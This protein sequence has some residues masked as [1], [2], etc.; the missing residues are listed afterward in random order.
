MATKSCLGWNPVGGGARQGCGSTLLLSA[1]FV[2]AGT[3]RQTLPKDSI[4]GSSS[5][6]HC[7]PASGLTRLPG[8]RG[9]AG[10]DQHLLRIPVKSS[11]SPEC[12]EQLATAPLCPEFCAPRA[13]CVRAQ[14][15]ACCPTPPPP[16]PLLSG[17]H[18]TS[19]ERP[20]SPL[21]WLWPRSGVARS[22]SSWPGSPDLLKSD[23]V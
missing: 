22:P 15:P 12:P 14:S 16:P 6:S 21:M 18:H 11:W 13:G 17:N 9:R 3:D 4:E 8:G 10:G 1:C 5:S 7:T 20:G 23:S 2:T 19:P